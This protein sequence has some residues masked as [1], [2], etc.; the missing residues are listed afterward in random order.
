M[1]HDENLVC[2]WLLASA[3]VRLNQERAKVNP[4]PINLMI[5][6]RSVEHALEMV[7]RG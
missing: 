5:L 3:R 6:E 4:D 2:L 1:S 7:E